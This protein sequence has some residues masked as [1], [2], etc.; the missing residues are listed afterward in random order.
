MKL[1]AIVG[2]MLVAIGGLYAAG[3]WEVWDYELRHKPEATKAFA[4]IAYDRCVDTCEKSQQKG[5][6]LNRLPGE[7]EQP[8]KIDCSECQVHLPKE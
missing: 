4:W 5:C 2:L 1:A 8:C 6:E 3:A 7:E